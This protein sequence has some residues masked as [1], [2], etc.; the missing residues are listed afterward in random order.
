[1]SSSYWYMFDKEGKCCWY[2]K[3]RYL[4]VLVTFNISIEKYIGVNIEAG[5]HKLN[6]ECILFECLKA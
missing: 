1:M 2:L 6:V 5:V 4:K 3:I